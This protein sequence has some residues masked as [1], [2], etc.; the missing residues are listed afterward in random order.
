MFGIDEA[1]HA[2]HDA[3]A[4]GHRPGQP[5]NVFPSIAFV[6]DAPGVGVRV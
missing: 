5:P 1:R 3:F 6:I 2:D 4:R